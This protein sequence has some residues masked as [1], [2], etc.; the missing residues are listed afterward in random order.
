MEYQRAYQAI[1]S[2]K[3]KISTCEKDASASG[4]DPELVAAFNLVKEHYVR[5]LKELD[6][7]LKIAISNL[8]SKKDAQKMSPDSI[9]EG[10]SCSRA[11]SATEATH[12]ARFTDGR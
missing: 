11:E 4:L 1:V 7:N 2:I 10:R 3:N 5:A 6:E 12:E 9:D 8:I